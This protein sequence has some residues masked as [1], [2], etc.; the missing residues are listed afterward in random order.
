M[1]KLC[2]FCG[3]SK[4]SAPHFLALANELG[5]KMAERKIGLVYGG[6]SIG[7]MGELAES[8]LEK[9]G[10]VFGVIPQKLVDWEVAHQGLTELK[11]VD[12]MHARKEKMYEW[13][14]GFV[15]LPG[16][17]GTLDEFCEILTWAQLEYHSKPCWLLNHQD[18]YGHWIQHL[19][20]TH[21]NG[22]LSSGHL[23][24]VRIV[25]GV[26]DLLDDF[27]QAISTK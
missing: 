15:A 19:R 3:S 26:S 13:A 8:C 27:E 16:G 14:D 5:Q 23:E 2:V 18:F 25:D 9:N 6:S 10:Q 17:L 7:L 4:G 21:T 22:F 11:V 12:T 20:Q 1:K 24:L